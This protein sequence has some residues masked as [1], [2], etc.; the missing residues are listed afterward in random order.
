MHCILDKQPI[1]TLLA[2]ATRK[3]ISIDLNDFAECA[4]IFAAKAIISCQNSQRTLRR[5][6]FRVDCP[7]L[8]FRDSDPRFSMTLS[9]YLSY[10]QVLKSTKRVSVFGRK[11]AP[12][13]LAKSI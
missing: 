7:H 9:S 1:G 13:A 12:H 6:H 11:S 8:Q 3:A 5:N 2:I 10:Q 4:E